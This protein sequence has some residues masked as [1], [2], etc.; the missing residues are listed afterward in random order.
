M[1]AALAAAASGGATAERPAPSA[2]SSAQA[3]EPAALTEPMSATVD[4]MAFGPDGRPVTDLTVSDI[5]LKI[6]GRGPRR[7]HLLQYVELDGREGLP[8]GAGPLAAPLPVPFASNLPA[9][10]GRSVLIVVNHETISPGRERPV[11]DA[12]LRF[13]AGLSPRD[14]VGLYTTPRGTVSVSSTRDHEEIRSALSRITGSA[15]QTSTQGLPAVPRVPGVSAM[16]VSNSD[17]ACTTRL[18][19]GDLSVMLTTLASDEPKTIVFI[20]SGLMPPTRD[21]PAD[22]P[23]G[24]CELKPEHYNEVGAAAR[25]ARA[26]FYVVQP[27][28]VVADPASNMLT[29][30]TSSRFSQADDA[31]AGLQNLAGVTGGEIF[32][33][34][35][36]PDAV[37]TRVARESSG[38]YIADFVPDPSERNG[39]A[40]GVD[41][42]VARPDVKLRYQSQIVLTRPEARKDPKFLTPH[43]MIRGARRFRTLPLRAAAF[44][45]RGDQGSALK[46]IAL[47]E[48]MDPSVGI[49]AAAMGLV[50][51]RNR[52]VNQWT[53]E[54]ADLASGR[55]FAAFPASQGSYRLRVAAIDTAG[56]HGTVEYPFTADLG[57]AGGFKL[58]T[59]VLGVS[60][61][62]S[63]EPK[64]IFGQE[65]AAVAYL[66]LYGRAREP[67]IRLEL[68]ESM[69]G[70]PVVGVP[71]RITETSD[72]DRRVAVAALPI[73]SVFPG[74]YVVRAVVT[75]DGKPLG[76]TTRTLRKVVVR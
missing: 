9:D 25:A 5:T 19:L 62:N 64:M 32:Q 53:A 15:P 13:L 16:E 65:E 17:R 21:A 72:P 60:R 75:D 31:V 76:R 27:Y 69:E 14:R 29:D 46:V 63:F 49:V 67:V 38:Y 37:F 71:A 66:E 74:D 44:T 43:D 73:G 51:S 58:S 23:P 8:R 68:A 47:A 36:A 52:L 48:P 59:I 55:L 2:P 24:P 11:R 10:A 3:P 50:D 20:S 12:A 57:S 6:D 70:A 22:R 30:M 40:H 42:Q 35:V 41:I 34:T 4:F 33:L 61:N 26:H 28:D 45:S 1:V 54:K 39:L 56:R 7:V 18:T